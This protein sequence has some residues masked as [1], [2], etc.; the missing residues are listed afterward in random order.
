MEGLSEARRADIRKM[1]DL[2]L[3]AKLGQAGYSADDLEAMDR[4]AMLN[5]WAELVLAGK[6]KPVAAATP[7]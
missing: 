4:P 1:S 6:D 5:A 7:G 2:R 3:A